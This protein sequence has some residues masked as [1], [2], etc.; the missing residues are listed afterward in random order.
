MGIGY[1]FPLQTLVFLAL[2]KATESVYFCGQGKLCTSVYGD[3]MIFHRRLYPYVLQHFGEIGFVINVEKTFHDSGFRESC[4]GDYYH[5]VDVRPFQPRN[6]AAY[7]PDKEY[8]AMLYKWINGLL[9]RWSEHEIGFTLQYLTTELEALVNKCKIVPADFPDDSGI[10]CNTLT[11]PPFLEHVRTAKPKHIGHGVFRFSFLRLVS[12]T[13]KE[14][15]H[16]PYFWNAL[17]GD[18][19]N[20]IEDYSRCTLQ[21]DRRTTI[22]RQVERLVSLSGYVP[23]LILV[24]DTPIV[25]TGETLTGDCLRSRTTSV[26]VSHTGR[27]KRQSGT[28]CFEAAEVD[29]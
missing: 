22:I 17:R 16:E 6:G 18:C 2:L 20:A 8:E 15:R 7:I 10:K 11:L 9:M 14:K 5:G 13:R 25:I 28:S 23:P 1:T 3:D 4:G 19:N 21:R 12:E 27:Y 29:A 26:T 24:E